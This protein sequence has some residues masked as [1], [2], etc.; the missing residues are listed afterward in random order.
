MFFR[1][2]RNMSLRRPPPNKVGDANRSVG[3]DLVRRSR[4]QDDSYASPSSRLS[5]K[6]AAVLDRVEKYFDGKT[7]LADIVYRERLSEDVVLLS[8]Q[9]ASDVVAAV[10]T[11]QG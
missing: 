10:V 1:L 9:C 5:N 2:D 7:T 3:V 6:A 4:S 11:P 8:L